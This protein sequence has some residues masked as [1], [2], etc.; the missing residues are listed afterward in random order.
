MIWIVI[1]TIRRRRVQPFHA[2]AIVFIA[3]QYGIGARL[4]LGTRSNMTCSCI[5]GNWLMLL[6]CDLYRNLFSR[7]HPYITES[8]VIH[9][10]IPTITVIFI[11]EIIQS[12][13]ISLH[14]ILHTAMRGSMI[15]TQIPRDGGFLKPISF[16]SLLSTF[17]E[18]AK[19]CVLIE[20]RVPIWEISPQLSC[21]DTCQI[22][23]LLKGLKR[24]I[25]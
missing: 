5:N 4:F 18:L 24:Y 15:F 25:C 13:S 17:S 20:Y 14:G 2:V 21:G 22:W 7:R 6:S 3:W 11:K 9:S 8:L 19:Y 12:P 1:S 16:F 23:T 10:Y